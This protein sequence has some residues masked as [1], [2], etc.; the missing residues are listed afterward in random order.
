MANGRGPVVFVA[1]L[2]ICVTGTEGI[3]RHVVVAPTRMSSLSA[4]TIILNL[5]CTYVVRVAK[6]KKKLTRKQ[7]FCVFLWCSLAFF[8]TPLFQYVRWPVPP[9]LIEKRPRSFPCHTHQTRVPSRH[10]TQPSP[11]PLL[12]ILPF[13]C[14]RH[15]FPPHQGVIFF[16][17]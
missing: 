17:N 13:C 11:I 2:C 14:F 10:N 7:H 5:S 16:T 12:L 15:S 1:A 4:R 3:E 8:V 6:K 9:T